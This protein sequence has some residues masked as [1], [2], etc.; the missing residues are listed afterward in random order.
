MQSLCLEYGKK[1]TLGP[2]VGNIVDFLRENYLKNLAEADPM[3]SQKEI[4]LRMRNILFNW[5]LEIHGKFKLKIRTLF[6]T[7]NI[8][9]R[10]LASHQI[11]RKQLQLVGIA[12]FLIASKF[13]DIYPPE[14]EEFCFLCEN[15]YSKEEILRQEENILAFLRFELIF[16][17]VQDVLEHYLEI[18][19]SQSKNLR[20][21]SQLI[22]K[23]FL[24]QSHLGKFNSFKLAAF[25]IDLAS[26]LLHQVSTPLGSLLSPQE[27]Q[28]LT[29]KLSVTLAQLRTDKLCALEDQ[30]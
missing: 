8:F 23:L 30:H 7:S 5:L 10:Y 24:F 17:S 9:D 16:V 6:L 3:G 29:E 26:K 13:E 15:V 14:L 11:S 22:A 12:S 19:D 18:L 25:S 28:F 1:D 27:E 21:F 2:Y 4:N 20:E